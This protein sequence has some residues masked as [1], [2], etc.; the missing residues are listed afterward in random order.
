MLRSIKY[1]LITILISFL[2]WASENDHI[3][4]VLKPHPIDLSVYDGQGSLLISWSIPD[5]IK[6]SE[7]NVF[8]MEFGQE[9]FELISLIPRGQSQYLDY[10]CDSGR[11]ISIN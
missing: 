8:A 1:I 2:L 6:V 10:N 3:P 11:V 4:D 5:S 9:Q 7:A